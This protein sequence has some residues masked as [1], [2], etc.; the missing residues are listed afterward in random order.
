MSQ[1]PNDLPIYRVLTGP[2]NA[3]F[4]RRVSEALEMGYQLHGSPAVTF[5]G[6]DV[7][8]AQAVLWPRTGD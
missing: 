8:V 3:A 5:N 7:I 4:C 2:D 6:S 1:P